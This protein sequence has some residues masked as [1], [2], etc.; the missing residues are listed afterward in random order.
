MDEGGPGRE[1][2]ARLGRARATAPARPRVASAVPRL[3][4]TAGSPRLRVGVSRDFLTASGALNFDAPVVAAAAAIRRVSTSS[5]SSSRPAPP[6]RRIRHAGVRCADDQAKP[7]WTRQCWMPRRAPGRHDATAIVGAQ[8]RR[9]RPHRR[10]RVHACGRDDQHHAGCRGPSVASSVLALMLAFSHR[11]FERD[12]MTRAGRW[13]ERWDD[14]RLV[15][16]GP[17]RSA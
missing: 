1:R 8:R 6:L 16:D 3:M 15:A 4:P 9:L 12:R 5:S 2:P 17:R 10:R 14:A 7:R 13:A 11:L